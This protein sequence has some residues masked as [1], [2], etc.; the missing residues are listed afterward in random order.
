MYGYEDSLIIDANSGSTATYSL[1]GTG[2]LSVGGMEVVGDGGSGYFNQS[3]G[4]NSINDFYGAL[5]LG[6][7]P[8]S[9]GT[10]IMMGGTLV[11]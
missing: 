8:G 7:F 6:L 3:G 9:T 11:S 10:Y 5:Y 1:S 2:S 4:T